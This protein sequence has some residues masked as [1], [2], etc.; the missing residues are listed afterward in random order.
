MTEYEK[1]LPVAV[2]YPPQTIENCL[3]KV[4]SDAGMKQ[5]HI[6]ET[7]KY[8][9]VTFFMNGMIENEFPG[10]DR[11]IIPRRASRLTTKRR[12]CRPCRSPNAW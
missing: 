10:E 12:R 2:A 8:A 3:A 4:V 11:A 6:A 9:H 1:D 7:E 5:L